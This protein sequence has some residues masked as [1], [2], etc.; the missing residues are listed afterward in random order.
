MKVDLDCSGNVI[1]FLYVY[2]HR[3]EH[4]LPNMSPNLV[5]IELTERNFVGSRAVV[6]AQVNRLTELGFQFAIDDFG[7][8]NREWLELSPEYIKLDHSII[9]DCQKSKLKQFLIRSLTLAAHEYGIKVI[10]EGVETVDELNVC[11][12]NGVTLVQGYLIGRPQ[13][14]STLVSE[15]LQSINANNYT[16]K[17]GV[18][19]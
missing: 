19:V 12:G 3:F 8:G 7:I 18:L 10:A 6:Q 13:R 17:G 1:G 4:L 15:N 5:V 16:I 14:L 2:G 11:L 9:H